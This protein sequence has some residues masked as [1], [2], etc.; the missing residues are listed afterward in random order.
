[1]Q[2]SSTTPQPPG[3]TPHRLSATTGASFPP[4]SQTDQVL[5]GYLQ[6]RGYRQTAQTFAQEVKIRSPEGMILESMT[7]KEASIQGA[8]SMYG[9]ASLGTLSPRDYEDQYSVLKKW[10]ESSLDMFKVS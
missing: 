3:Q 5:L 4:T 2:S 6:R 8:V 10:T 1:M 9:N 7:R